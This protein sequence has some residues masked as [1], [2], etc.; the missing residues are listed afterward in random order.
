[1]K[2]SKL[3]TG[4][5]VVI[6]ALLIG[7]GFSVNMPASAAPGAAPTPLGAGAGTGKIGNSYVEWSNAQSVTADTEVCRVIEDFEK[8]DMH[9]FVDITNSNTVTM[10]VRY[11]N[12]I[13][14][15]PVAGT[16]LHTGV[17]TDTNDL[18]QVI[19]MGRYGCVLIDVLNATPVAITVNALGK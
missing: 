6:I 4:I 3:F 7:L 13:G 15:T 12:R 11:T 10:T 16:T 5:L 18:D 17:S 1:M 9:S 14:L 19:A 2:D 8:L